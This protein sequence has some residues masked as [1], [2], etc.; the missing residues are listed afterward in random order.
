MIG[1]GTVVNR[2]VPPFVMAVGNPVR[3]VGLNHVGLERSGF[4]PR[5]FP[6]V[7]ELTEALLGGRAVESLQLPEPLVQAWHAF[8]QQVRRGVAGRGRK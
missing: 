5:T 1:M 4:D 8:L 6:P 2:D 3:I 7:E